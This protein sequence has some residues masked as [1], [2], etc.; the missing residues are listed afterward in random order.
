MVE[1]IEEHLYNRNKDFASVI[2]AKAMNQRL[3][4]KQILQ[5]VDDLCSSSSGDE[6]P[7]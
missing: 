1:K 4:Y 3:A 2:E 6:E 7:V 5:Q